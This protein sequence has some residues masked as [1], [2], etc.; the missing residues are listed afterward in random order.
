M[1]RCGKC[2]QSLF[3]RNKCVCNTVTPGSSFNKQR[4][5][6]SKWCPKPNCGSRVING[7]CMNAQC[8]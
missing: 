5:D 6:P 8:K 1:A 7:R 3:P 4:N 2:R